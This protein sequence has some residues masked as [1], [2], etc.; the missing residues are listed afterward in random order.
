MAAVNPKILYNFNE[1]DAS[2]IRDYSE[3]GEDATG[4]NMVVQ[5]SSRTGNEAVF[6]GS[7]SYMTTTAISYLSDVDGL[8]ITM[9]IKLD[10]ATGTDYIFNI[11]GIVACTWDG[12]TL[13]SRLT[14]T[15]SSYTVTNDITALSTGT[16]YDISLRLNSSTNNWRMFVNGVSQTQVNTSGNTSALSPD[17]DLG[18]DGSTAYGNFDLNEFRLYAETVPNDTGLA[19]INEQNGVLLESGVP[20]GFNAGDVIGTGINSGVEKYAIVTNADSTFQYRI[21]P[22]SENIVIGERFIRCGHLWDT[23]RQWM[24]IMDDT[25]QIC[26][27]DGI[28]KSS[29]ILAASKKV[30]CL[31]SAGYVINTVTKSANY[32]ATNTDTR[33]EVDC[34][35][36]DITITM[37][38]SPTTNKEW[39]IVDDGGA[40]PNKITVDGNGKNINGKSSWDITEPYE[41]R[42]MYYNGTE[43]IM[44]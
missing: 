40:N 34:S 10:T 35:G 14:T 23:A 21:Q 16:Y 4:T 8:T 41:V 29:E 38:A 15:V 30:Y 44:I 32:T 27:Y 5:A 42:K 39:E 17:L 7:T 19:L 26:Y 33:I 25:P 43:Y 11:A 20:H 24:F 37:P 12:T 9:G 31:N 2:T 1:N 36:G 6:D 3:N 22:I 18:W 28:S 13:S